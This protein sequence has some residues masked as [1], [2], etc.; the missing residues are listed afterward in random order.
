MTAYVLSLAAETDVVEIWQYTES[1]WSEAQAQAYH[2]DLERRFAR[3]SDGPFRTLDEI[4]LGLRVSRAGRHLI[5]WM[6]EPAESTFVVAVLHE[7]MDVL[8]RLSNRLPR[9]E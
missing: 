1:K 2:A 3:L 8:T 7:K 9:A 4:A 6:K 5:Y